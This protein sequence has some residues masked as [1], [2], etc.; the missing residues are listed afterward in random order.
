LHQLGADWIGTNLAVERSTLHSFF[1][2]PATT[3][4][5]RK[6]KRAAPRVAA[7]LEQLRGEQRSRRVALSLPAAPARLTF[8]GSPAA[9]VAWERRRL[10]TAFVAPANC[11]K[12]WPL[13]PRIL[14]P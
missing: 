4:P 12:N 5:T 3:P 8:A 13:W 11:S 14:R 6:N 9:G 7:V 1:A 10:T 2:D